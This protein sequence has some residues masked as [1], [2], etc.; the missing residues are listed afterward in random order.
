[1]STIGKG[2]IKGVILNIQ[3]THWVLVDFRGYS[4]Q[5]TCAFTDSIVWALAFMHPPPT[6]GQWVSRA[7]ACWPPGSAPAC[8]SGLQLGSPGL[9]H[10][11]FGH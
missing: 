5:A 9:P 11:V 4:Q 6:Q 7:A 3:N 10:A 8:T 1:M 2:K